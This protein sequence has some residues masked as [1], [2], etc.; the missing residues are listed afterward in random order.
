M[1]LEKL[2]KRVFYICIKIAAYEK[3]NI[4]VEMRML[5][6]ELKSFMVEFLEANKDT[7]PEEYQIVQ[8]VLLELME[9]IVEGIKQ[10]DVILLED[11]CQYGLIRFLEI[12]FTEEEVQVLRKDAINEI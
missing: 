10:G 3:F 6:P 2:Y 12:F 4:V 11:T 8:G 9:D 7:E 5:L 1:N